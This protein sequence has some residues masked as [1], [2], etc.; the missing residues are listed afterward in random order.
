MSAGPTWEVTD[1]AAAADIAHAAGARVAVDG[2]V[3]TPVLT[4]PL[5]RGA[6]LVMHSATKYLTGHGDLLAGVL[7]TARDDD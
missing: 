7:V 2:T 3:A 1:I 4:R 5:A 6:D